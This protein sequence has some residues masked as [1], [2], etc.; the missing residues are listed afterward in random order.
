MKYGKVINYNGRVG[1]I[2]TNNDVY[3]F[4]VM[5]LDEKIDNGNIVSFNI[6]D[7]K[8][9]IV[10]DIKKYDNESLESYIKRKKANIL[11][12]NIQ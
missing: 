2:V 7:N 5:G 10:T 9:K 12:N 1:Q 8:L 4:S 3:V 6:K 11:N